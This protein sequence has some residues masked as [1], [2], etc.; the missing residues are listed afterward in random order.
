MGKTERP[1]K[2][3]PLGGWKSMYSMSVLKEML[4]EAKHLNNQQMS[5]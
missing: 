3:R 4:A 5:V 1:N 2:E